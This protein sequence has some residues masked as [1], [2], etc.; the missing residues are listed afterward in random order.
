MWLRVGSLA[1]TSGNGYIIWVRWKCATSIT[2]SWYRSSFLDLFRE[3]P[4]LNL[5]WDTSYPDS[6]DRGFLQSF[7]ANSGTI[8]RLYHDRF[9][10]NY[11][12]LIAH[13]SSYARHSLETLAAQRGGRQTLLTPWSRVLLEKLT[14]FA[15][16]QEIPRILWNPKVHY[17][18]HKR[19]PPVPILSQPHPVPTTPSHFLK[20]GRQ[21]TQQK[22]YIQ[23]G[24][25]PSCE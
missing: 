9:L 5:V 4:S 13:Q 15:A 6:Y 11:F 24:P 10:Q 12:Q 20:I 18:T 21:T 3:E 14:G 7:H 8:Y 19:P 17:L 2:G 25:R 1:V 23:K 22:P 16:N